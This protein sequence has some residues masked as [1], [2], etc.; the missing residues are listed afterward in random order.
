MRTDQAKLDAAEPI[1]VTA[2]IARLTERNAPTAE[3]CH[4]C[5]KEV[6]GYDTDVVRRGRTVSHRECYN[7]SWYALG[8]RVERRA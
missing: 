8:G 4:V 5:G 7:N 2:A 6:S 3:T 1:G